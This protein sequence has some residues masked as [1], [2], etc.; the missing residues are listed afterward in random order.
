MLHIGLW[1]DQSR[2]GMVLDMLFDALSS[3][4][5][6][7][8]ILALL[9]RL[10]SKPSAQIDRLVDASFTIYL[11]HHPVVVGLA[12]V[13]ITAAVPPLLAWVAICLGAF[14]LPYA[15]HRLLRR[16]PLALWLFNGVRPKERGWG[17]L[18][19]ARERAPA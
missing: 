10:A 7:Q 6:V 17:M 8:T 4:C 19:G 14:A 3:A 9:L 18:V 11:L 5:L 2:L 1:D 15:A 16:S 13:C 12:I